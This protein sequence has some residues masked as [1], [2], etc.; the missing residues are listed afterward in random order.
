MTNTKIWKC[1]VCKKNIDNNQGLFVYS[2]S[3]PEKGNLEDMNHPRFETEPSGAIHI[4]C[5]AA[6]MVT[7]IRNNVEIGQ[8]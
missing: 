3:I 1:E 5:L 7:P 4:T 6:S 8:T 2:S